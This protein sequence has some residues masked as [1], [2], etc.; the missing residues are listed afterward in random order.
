YTEDLDLY[1]A[2]TE[3]AMNQFHEVTNRPWSM[4]Q[5]F[6]PPIYSLLD[7]WMPSRALDDGVTATSPSDETTGRI[8]G[9][10]LPN[11]TITRPKDVV[12]DFSAI[13][14]LTGALKIPVLRPVQIRLKPLLPTVDTTLATVP[15][16]PA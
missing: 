2:A 3:D 10:N 5:R 6:E 4:N 15:T 8:S 7:E 14:Y 13:T 12:L 11:L 1:W 16:A 9:D